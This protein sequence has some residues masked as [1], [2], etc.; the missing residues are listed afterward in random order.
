MS[1]PPGPS[2]REGDRAAS[3]SHGVLHY[4]PDC[5]FCARCAA[6]LRRL[7]VR[8]DIVAWRGD[9][10]HLDHARA[11]REIPFTGADGRVSHG[12]RAIADALRTAPG[13]PGTLGRLLGWPPALR[14][15]APV[16]RWA[17]RHRHRLPG[18]TAACR[19]PQS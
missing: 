5:G 11:A 14:I 7:G 18:G 4:D 17:A 3:G 8:A 19:L 16:Y 12:A 2:G 6:W 10:P 13:L 15:A 9:E 1:G